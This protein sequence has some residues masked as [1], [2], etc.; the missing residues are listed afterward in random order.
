MSSKAPKL[1]RSNSSVDESE[2]GYSA[3]SQSAAASTSATAKPA[4]AAPLT[5]NQTYLNFG[6]VG[7][8][9][10]VAQGTVHWTQTTMVRQQ[11]QSA[12]TGAE[13]SF[14]STLAGVYSSEGMLGLYR[15]FSSAAFREMTYSSLR[16]GLYEPLKAAISG[17]S[18]GSTAPW[19][20]VLA[21][22]LAGTFAAGVASPTDLLTVRQMRPGPHLG[23]VET[24]RAVVTES[25]LRGLYRGID[26]TV[27]RAAILGGTK[28]GCY[29][30]VKQVRPPREPC[31]PRTPQQAANRRAAQEL[32]K[33]G[34]S[35]GLGLVFV[36]STLTGLAVTITTSPATNART[37]IMTSPPGTYSGLLGCLSSI[38]AQQG[39][40]GLFRGF[41][42]QWLRFGPYAVV[43]FT[44]WE[45]LRI[46]CGMKPI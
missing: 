1:K 42:A 18:G 20:N 44:V 43:Q 38:V 35:D 45:Q 25:G 28:M 33:A 2:S 17:S 14:V 24:A 6:L 16:F 7:A 5:R 13:P 37:L 15:G 34:W 4:A 19:Q 22:L 40:L 32:R 39:P 12:A 31:P 29:D 41:A 46:L 36:A 21:G 3:A 27:T 30:T 11:L 10:T 23:M 8:S 26:T 9:C